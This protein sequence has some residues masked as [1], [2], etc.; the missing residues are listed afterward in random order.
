M[1]CKPF[2]YF[3]SGQFEC[4]APD[5]EYKDQKYSLPGCTC[6]DNKYSC[7]GEVTEK[8]T[9]EMNT[10]TTDILQDLDTVDFIN[11]YLLD[12]FEQFIEKR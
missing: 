12:S 1:K 8:T 4:I 10:T 3:S 7:T 6:E 11:Q 2:F 9:P 5:T